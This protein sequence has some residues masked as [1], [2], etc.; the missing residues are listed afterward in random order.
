MSKLHTSIVCMAGVLLTAIGSILHAETFPA[1]KWDKW[2][3]AAPSHYP[4]ENW[5]KYATPEDAGW[6]SQGLLSA[7]QMSERAGSAAVMMI[8][9]GAVLA[10]WGEAE[11]RYM[12]HSIR[13]SLHR[14]HSNRCHFQVTTY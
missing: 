1:E 11:R 4:D 7:R 8:Y 14:R 13:S 10:Q 5:H 2:N 3:A 12:R 6:S 9:N